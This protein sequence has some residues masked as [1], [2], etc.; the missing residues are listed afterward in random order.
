MYDQV[1]QYCKTS[2][3]TL[4]HVQQMLQ[5]HDPSWLPWQRRLPCCSAKMNNFISLYVHHEA[6]VTL[7]K[8]H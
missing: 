4:V 6:L 2:T 5:S 1:F 7:P 8:L 3:S